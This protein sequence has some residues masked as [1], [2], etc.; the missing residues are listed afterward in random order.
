MKKAGRWE[1]GKAAA[2]V[3]LAGSRMD[4]NYVASRPK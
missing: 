4:E 2:G 1:N 3:S